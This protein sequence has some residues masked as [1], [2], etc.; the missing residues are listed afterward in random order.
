MIKKLLIG[1]A[2]LA[3]ASAFAAPSDYGFGHKRDDRPEH[4]RRHD[5]Q[6]DDVVLTKA[7][8]KQ[9][10]FRDDDNNKT[11]LKCRDHGRLFRTERHGRIQEIATCGKGKEYANWLILHEEGRRSSYDM[12]GKNCR[13][14]RKG[15]AC[16]S[17]EE[18]E[19]VEFKISDESRVNEWDDRFAVER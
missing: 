17:W 15:W 16:T 11:K 3:S 10:K 6:R 9:V 14:S 4:H 2:L 8:L 13:V 1:A 19:R 18:I 5:S 7:K 12:L